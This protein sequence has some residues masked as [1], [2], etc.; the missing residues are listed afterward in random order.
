MRRTVQREYRGW[1]ITLRSM[2]RGVSAAN[3]SA[4]TYSAIAQA[5]L[6][7]GQNASDWVD[8]RMQILS[9]GNRSFD[10]PEACIEALY[11]EVKQLIDALHR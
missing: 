2:H 1:A 7:P 9:T 4:L 8:P 6:L 11:L 3:G 5:E 10:C